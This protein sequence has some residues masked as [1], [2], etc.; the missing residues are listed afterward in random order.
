VRRNK[1]ALLSSLARYGV[2]ND[3][4]DEVSNYYRYRRETGELWRHVDAE[5]FAMV[6]GGKI[7]SI[8]ITNPGAGYSSA[9]KVSVQAGLT[10]YPL[11]I[12]SYGKDLASNGSIS[13]I[14]TSPIGDDNHN[15]PTFIP[16][17]IEIPQTPPT[18]QNI[19]V[20]PPPP[21]PPR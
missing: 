11:A 6:A 10:E 18:P 21:P 16:N 15:L 17:E 5:G 8:T 3:R 2:T 19:P 1:E 9:P 13:K 12:V 7:V 14:V 4:L 20:P